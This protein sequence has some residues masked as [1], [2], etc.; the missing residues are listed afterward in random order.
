[1][2]AW[3]PRHAAIRPA[4][5]RATKAL[6]SV[7]KLADVFASETVLGYESI[8]YAKDTRGETDRQ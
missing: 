3:N 7:L 8:K 6:P 1:M 5:Q 4:L 2:L